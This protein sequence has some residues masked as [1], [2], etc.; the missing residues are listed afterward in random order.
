MGHYSGIKIVFWV[1]TERLACIGT[2]DMPFELRGYF[3]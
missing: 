1:V 2:M 3:G